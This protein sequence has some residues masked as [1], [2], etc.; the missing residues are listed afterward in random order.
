M[1]KKKDLTTQY[2]PEVLAKR[3][4][5]LFNICQS[6]EELRA[7]LKAF[8][9]ADLP[10]YT[11]DPMSNSNPMQFVWEVYHTMATNDGPKSHVVAASR[12]SMKTL[13][14]AVLHFLAMVHFRRNCVHMAAIKQQSRKCI[15]YL[16][17]FL[18]IPE[19]RDYFE[20]NS[21][22]EFGLDNLP[23]TDYTTK[24]DA[25]IIVV[26]ATL[27]GANSQRGNFVLTDELDLVSR[28]I[29]SEVAMVGDPD[30][31]N[32]EPIYVS[33][34]SRK[35]NSGPI[36]DKIEQA[37][38]PE[39]AQYIRLHKWNILEF[40]K[41]CTPDIHGKHG[42]EVFINDA[43][44]QV[45]WKEDG[46]EVNEKIQTTFR[47]IVA[48]ENCKTCP[49]FIT[50]QG[51]APNQKSDSKRLRTIAFVG[52]LIRETNS[53]PKIKAQLLN[54]E[55]ETDG[56][57]FPLFHKD[58]HFRPPSEVWEKMF[59]IPWLA[60]AKENK[61][62]NLVPDKDDFYQ[63]AKIMKWKINIGVDFGYRDPAVATVVLYHP[64]TKMAVILHTEHTTGKTNSQWGEY[65]SVNIASK[66]EPDLIC[67][68]MQD[69]GCATYFT[70]H[71]FSV[72]NKK[73]KL[74]ETGISQL[75]S[76]MW[77]PT[78][79]G[80]NFYVIDHDDDNSKWVY[81]CLRKHSHPKASNGTFN[82]DNFEDS[83]HDHIS[84]AIRYSLEPFRI[85]IEARIATKQ[86]EEEKSQSNHVLDAVHQTYKDQGAQLPNGMSEAILDAY[87][88]AGMSHHI[89]D[90]PGKPSVKQKKKSAIK[91]TF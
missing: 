21:A 14:S 1:S 71:G 43:T 48:Y 13:T 41:K 30:V 78:T 69:A 7:F 73:P 25:E 90:D 60:F 33:L 62:M 44:L 51:R 50:C 8:L 46:K 79:Q 84:D 2:S 37:E 35:T 53:V 63:M 22:Y 74:I 68:D 61:K 34:S 56:L 36:Q 38:K 54:L 76:L 49:I 3:R 11:V 87:R 39:N 29:L 27:E 75:R 59:G 40:T 55:P 16:K 18:K 5:Y 10:D 70:P 17:S 66:F 4:K 72:Y 77:D 64:R 26:A 91:F 32:F 24:Q 83:D 85:Q 65:V 42:Q 58:T 89:I 47:K 23:P 81:D 15:K 9:K 12:N 80:V 86:R 6:K 88:A 57:V 52:D 45:V 67:P 82:M 28:E 20:T 19:L 31:N